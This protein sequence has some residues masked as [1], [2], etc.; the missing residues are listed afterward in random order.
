MKTVNG[1]PP[2][3][4]DHLLLECAAL[5][6]L[7]GFSSILDITVMQNSCVKFSISYSAGFEGVQNLKILDLGA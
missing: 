7:A 5:V 6:L 1:K 2:V 3:R 4:R